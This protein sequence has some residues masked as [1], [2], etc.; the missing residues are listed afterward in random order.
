MVAA[1]I[2]SAAVAA[3]PVI[4]LCGAPAAGKS[5]VAWHLLRVLADEQIRA[6]YVDIDQLGMVYPPSEADRDRHQAKA[7]A[8]TA[9]MPNYE[10]AG[11]Q[12]LIVSG[13][14]DPAL[15]AG[16]ARRHPSVVFCH[17]RAS[18]ETLRGR[19]A[20]RKGSKES[21]DAAIAM[22]R[23]L[24]EASFIVRTID[25]TRRA[26]GDVASEVRALVRPRGQSRHAS[27]AVAAHGQGH[28]TVVCG[29]RAVGKSSVSWEM[30]QRA[31]ESGTATGYVDLEQLGFL[32]PADKGNSTLRVANL[33]G[34]WNTFRPLGAHSMIANG[35]I[36]VEDARLIHSHFASVSVHLVRLTADADTYRD[37][38]RR[39]HAG[40]PARLAGDDLASATPEH[41]ERVLREALAAEARY[42]AT[43]P[44]DAVIDTRRLSASEVAEL[45]RRT[46]CP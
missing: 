38:I 21:A 34:L 30:F 42:Q 12:V 28:L 10:G 23:G 1:R 17:L 37:R 15:G 14:L 32:Q 24:D 3:L 9:V 35:R 40:G 29:P 7:T 18:E 44:A 36:D 13:V 2:W 39:R 41:Q 43:D 31:F 11:A 6:G 26:P 27:P 5:T 45:I 8:L 4:W 22:M 20:A 16:F 46:G 19:L 33:A 25:T